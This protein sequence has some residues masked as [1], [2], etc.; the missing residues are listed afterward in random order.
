MDKISD[1]IAASRA[2]SFDEF[3][4][5]RLNICSFVTFCGVGTICD[6]TVVELVVG[7]AA[8]IFLAIAK[9]GEKQL[10]I[11]GVT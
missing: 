11:V 10:D 7:A 2:V 4:S 9:A 6:E 8:A 3:A 1:E 5:K